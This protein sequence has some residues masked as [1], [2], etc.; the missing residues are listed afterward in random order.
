[1]RLVTVLIVFS[2][3][4]QLSAQKKPIDLYLIG[5]QSNATGQGYMANIPEDFTIDTTVLFFYS[6]GLG[7]GGKSMQ[8]GQ[9]LT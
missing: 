9:V 4:C 3:V 7:G 8:W 5:G 6:E 2:F 1:M